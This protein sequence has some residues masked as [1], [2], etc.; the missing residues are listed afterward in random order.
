MLPDPVVELADGSTC[1]LTGLR[2][3]QALIANPG[4]N[5]DFLPAELATASRRFRNHPP[6]PKLHHVSTP[7]ALTKPESDL[8]RLD[9]R[10]KPS[11]VLYHRG[12]F[13]LGDGEPPP[14]RQRS[15]PSWKNSINYNGIAGTPAISIAPTTP[16]IQTE[17][18]GSLAGKSRSS[19]RRRSQRRSSSSNRRVVSTSP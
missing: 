14:S 10:R 2:R 17:D 15:V 8:P 6:F 18:S 19:T 11:A 12:L 3:P 9:H 16:V 7:L 13:L 5:Y 4:P 1:R